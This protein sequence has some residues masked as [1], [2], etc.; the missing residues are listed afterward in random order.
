[1]TGHL[2]LCEEGLCISCASGDAVAA[3]MARD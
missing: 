1:M 3:A 2:S